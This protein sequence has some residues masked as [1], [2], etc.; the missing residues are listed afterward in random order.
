[1]TGTAF[2]LAMHEMT[3]SLGQDAVYGSCHPCAE[4]WAVLFI[5]PDGNH[6]STH[7]TYDP[8]DEIEEEE[9]SSTSDTDQEEVED[10][11][12]ELD[13]NYHQLRDSILKLVEEYEIPRIRKQR[14]RGADV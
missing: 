14:A 6:L 7:M 3:Q 5:S 9:N 2:T 11:R 10:E 12:P 8:D 13:K 4:R 1:M